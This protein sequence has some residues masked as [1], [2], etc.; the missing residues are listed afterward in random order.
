[1]VD[2]RS[3]VQDCGATSIF[4]IAKH[5]M[6]TTTMTIMTWE[7]PT[8][9]RPSH[10]IVTIYINRGNEDDDPIVH[11][12]HEP[13]RARE[14]AKDHTRLD[15]RCTGLTPRGGGTGALIRSGAP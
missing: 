14:G 15:M 9:Q 6:T 7:V 4:D 11:H 8:T 5:T 10:L 1:M 3:K 12:Q 2:P 13:R